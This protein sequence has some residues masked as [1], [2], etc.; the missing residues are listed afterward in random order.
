MKLIFTVSVLVFLAA[1][2]LAVEQQKQEKSK[3]QE[4]RKRG[5]TLILKTKDCFR[6]HI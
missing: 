2:C 3:L 6:K 1:V 5:D 4:V